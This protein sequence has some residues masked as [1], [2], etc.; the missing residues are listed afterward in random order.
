MPP[1]AVTRDRAPAFI[2]LAFEPS[3]EDAAREF[4]SCRLH[5]SAR[6][7]RNDGASSSSMLAAADFSTKERARLTLANPEPRTVRSSRFAFRFLLSGRPSDERARS[8]RRG[9]QHQPRVHEQHSLFLEQTALA[10]RAL[11]V[12]PMCAERLRGKGQN[13]MDQTTAKLSL[14]PWP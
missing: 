9:L 10:L 12:A 6:W 11:G 13:I 2:A 14:R 1:T 5:C 3:Q 7:R 8:R 4:S